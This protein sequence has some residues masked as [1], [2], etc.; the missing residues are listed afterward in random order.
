MDLRYLTTNMTLI[1]ITRLKIVEN[2]LTG[3]V[4]GQTF[5][6]LHR[7]KVTLEVYGNIIL[8]YLLVYYIN[9]TYN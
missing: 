7:Y 8:Y 9:F 6:S 2:G 4:I 1:I 3:F 5:V